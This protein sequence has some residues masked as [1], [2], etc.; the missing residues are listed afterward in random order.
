[1]VETPGGEEHSQV[2]PS[3]DDVEPNEE[4]GPIARS[5]FNYQDEI[6]VWFLI[7]ML[8]SPLLLKVHC[9][10]HDDILLLRAKDGS[11]IRIAEFVQVKASAPDKLWS[12]AD[13]CSRKNSRPDSSIFE[14][15][16]ARDKHCEESRFRLVTLRPVVSE[17]E[18]LTFPF[19]A[20]GREARGERF[21]TLRSAIDR[22][23]PNLKS[24]KGN[25]V[26]YWLENCLWDQRHSEEAIRQDNL[27]RLIRLSS[28]ES[29]PM[30]MEPAEVF[31]VDLRAL[32]KAAGAARWVPD[33]DSKIITREA[34]REW[35][36]R[37]M[38]ELAEGA[39]APSGEKLQQKMIEAGLPDDLV[40]LALELRREYG[41][42][43]RTPRYM[44][45]EED[46]RL[47][48]RVRSE[49]LS[50]RSRFVAGQINLDGVGFHSL[51]V[52]RMDTINAERLQGSEDRSAFL[53]GCMYDIADRC[54]LRFARPTR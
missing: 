10:T 35:W 27:I 50:L 38:R 25:G 29:R 23:F 9:E 1:M 2:F 44:E 41:A 43:A 6:A 18:M 22:R 34:L 21:T 47:Q 46:K 51:C 17:L 36:D 42:L 45:L 16:L 12:V 54:L 49:A 48:N 37:R 24:P 28:K 20:P 33:R 14:I 19:G 13:L 32:A 7:E 3:V 5:G 53:K 30:L 40:G 11:A 26:A 4:G 15:S 39:V 31:L 8:E 52:D